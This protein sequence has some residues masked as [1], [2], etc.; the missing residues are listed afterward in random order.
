MNALYLICGLGIA[1][2]IAEIIN[3]KKWLVVLAAIGVAL[4]ALV[5]T[6][7]WNT[8]SSYFNDMLHVDNISI[9]FSILICLAGALWFWMAHNYF[10]DE[11]HITDQ[12]AL[13]L[14]SLVGALIL[15][16]FNNMSMLFLGIEILSI[17]LYVLAGSKKESIFSNE[18]AFKYFLMGS[19]A[20]GFLLMGIAL[21]YGATGSFDLIKISQFTADHHSSLPGFFYVGV[22]LIMIGMAFKVSVVPFHFWAP[23]VYQ[24]SPLAI[25]AF[26]STIVKIA[27]F[28]A[29][30][31]LFLNGFAVV[32]STW[33]F[34]LQSISI[35]TIL[36]SSITA[37][38]QFNIKRL[39]AYSSIGH[40][41]YVLL[42]LVTGSADAFGVVFYY[43]V[44]YSAA[45]LLAFTI[46]IELEKQNQETTIDDLKGLFRSSPLL[47][48]AL[49]VALLSMAGIPPFTGFIGKYLVLNLA[50]SVGYLGFTVVAI[51]TS[52][53]GV[54]Y[55]FKLIIAM[56]QGHA[57]LKEHTIS[58]S[59][60]L[61][62]YVLL[63]L[64]LV[65]GVLPSVFQIL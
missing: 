6:T 5:A 38:Y 18:A 65:A 49:T 3:F 52:L 21:I 25:T 47:A 36:I 56:F 53:I 32:Q 40:A 31:R 42:A 46:L 12:A 60:R 39:L 59:S 27:A 48:V 44:G 54:Y 11:T 9:A 34:I 15:T 23:D 19:F 30:L 64:V 62:I 10:H 26:M 58:L 45:S 13:I 17:S 24:G 51:F 63:L 43:L 16:S 20:T 57:E 41:G 22:L 28:A 2:L 55:Y 61:L 37:V 33:L 1:S 35:G 14:F 7:D 8:S 4:A 50:L 29:F